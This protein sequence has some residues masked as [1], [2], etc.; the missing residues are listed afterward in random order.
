M[1]RA[2]G[3]FGGTFAPIHNGHLRLARFAR[4]RLG[5]A[6]VRLVPAAV[7]PLRAA[8][9][10]AAARRLRWVK[11]AIAREPGLT[12][13]A[14]ELRRKG[15]SY[16][17]DTLESLRAQFPRASLCLL[18]GQD[19]AR[20]L[21]RWHRWRELPGLA[22]LVF[23][24]RPGARPALPAALAR[25]LR[26][27]RARSARELRQRPAGLWLRASLRPLAVSASDVR[28]RLATGLSVEGL[29]P[30]TVIRDF[31]RKDLEA[32]RRT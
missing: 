23:F 5:L 29:V 28:R 27:R 25:L 21:P 3:I 20:Q 17:V 19:S 31:T 1:T 15:P 18:L 11:L 6:E 24:G 13:D 4:T 9:P 30:D 2:I 7:P 22:H 8:P 32:F 14:R 16:T 10:I 12:A 26:G